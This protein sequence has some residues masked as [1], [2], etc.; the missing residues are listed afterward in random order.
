VTGGAIA[1]D[2]WRTG[3][4]LGLNVSSTPTSGQLNTLLT[5]VIQPL[6]LTWFNSVK[7]RFGASSDYSFL[8]CYY[9]PLGSH[10]AA[11]TGTITLSPVVGTASSN[12]QSPRTAL[13]VSKL[14]AYAGRANRGR[15]Y[16][17]CWGGLNVGTDGQTDAGTTGVYAN[18]TATLMSALNAANMSTAGITSQ[19]CIVTSATAAAIGHTITSVRCDGIM[20]T[21]RRRT[22]KDV[23]RVVSNSVV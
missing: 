2:I 5:G 11:A 1:G 9:Y 18:A 17:P 6:F 12:L 8:Q 22:N 7:V 14:T 21:Q 13:V 16:I 20:D 3:V 10:T 15:M 23:A 19:S 4:D